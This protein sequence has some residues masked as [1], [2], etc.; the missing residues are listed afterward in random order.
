[1]SKNRTEILIEVCKGCSLCVE[2][3]PRKII[4]LSDEINSSGYHPAEITDQEKCIACG[5]C[6]LVCPEPA[7]VVY[8]GEK[9]E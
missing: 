1:M 2:F 5:F 8:R 9:D 4:R 6:Y 7:V 3:C